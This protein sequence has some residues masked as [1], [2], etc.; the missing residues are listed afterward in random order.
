[1]TV[2]L[3]TLFVLQAKSTLDEDATQC[4]EVKLR[5]CDVKEQSLCAPTLSV[6]LL[7]ALLRQQRA[8][9]LVSVV[10]VRSLALA[11]AV[12]LGLAPRAT[13]EPFAIFTYLRYLPF[14]T[15]APAAANGYC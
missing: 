8:D 1:M 7:C 4:C 6:V 9:A 13:L 10:P 15:L 5:T 14:E 2:L 11:R 3:C 12:A